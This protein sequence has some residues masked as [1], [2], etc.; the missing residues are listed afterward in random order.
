MQFK[1]VIECYSSEIKRLCLELKPGKD[2][3]FIDCVYTSACSTEKTRSFGKANC[4]LDKVLNKRV[5]WVAWASIQTCGARNAIDDTCAT[6]SGHTFRFPCQDFG[7][8]ISHVIKTLVVWQR[9]WHACTV[10]QKYHVTLPTY[11]KQM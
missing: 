11:C 5:D 10:C 1:N 4:T 8:P 2:L 9:P 6:S 3:L 7:S